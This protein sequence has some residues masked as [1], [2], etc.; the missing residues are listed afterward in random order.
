MTRT[1]DAYLKFVANQG[2][3]KPDISRVALNITFEFQTEI[4]KVGADGIP[5][6]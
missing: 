6:L 2:R 5:P 4:L 3:C 1:V